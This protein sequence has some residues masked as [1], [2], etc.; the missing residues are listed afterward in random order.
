MTSE[1]VLKNKDTKQICCTKEFNWQNQIIEHKIF[2]KYLFLKTFKT[3]IL[4]L[5]LLLLLLFES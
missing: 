4:L 5:L 3:L 1:E 2:V